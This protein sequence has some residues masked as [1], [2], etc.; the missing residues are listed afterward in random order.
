MEPKQ[1]FNQICWICPEQNKT[2]TER[3]QRSKAHQETVHGILYRF[4]SGKEG[5]PKPS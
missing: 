5:F 3:L 2:S 1:R 4:F